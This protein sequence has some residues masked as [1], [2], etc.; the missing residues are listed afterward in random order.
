MISLRT[1]L[2]IWFLLLSGICAL[3]MGNNGVP[4]FF[5]NPVTY[6]GPGN[7]V[8]GSVTWYGLR[9]FDDAE[10]GTNAVNVCNSTGGVDVLCEDWITDVNG[11]LVAQTFSGVTCASLGSNCTIKTIYDQSGALQCTGSI[12]CNLTQATIASRPVLKT[13]CIGSL[14]CISCAPNDNLQGGALSTHAQ[15][16]TESIV[17]QRTANFTTQQ[18]PLSNTASRISFHTSANTVNLS[19]GSLFTKSSVNDSAFHAMQG[20]ASGASSSLAV[21]GST[22]T[23]SAGTNSLSGTLY[24]CDQ[25]SA[26]FLTGYILEGGY[27]P[28]GFS[29]GN[30]TAMNSNQH[31]YWGF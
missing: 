31:T 3:G 25:G 24:M 14:P 4:P 30:I 23:G 26:S 20:V 21:D 16:W 1:H 19:A 11:S 8:A 18:I 10:R 28:A 6:V 17:A 29:A 22:T 12:P 7:I 27:W 2:A 9:A 5:A 15:P 13:S